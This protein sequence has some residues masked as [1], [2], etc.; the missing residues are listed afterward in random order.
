[1]V[2]H[3]P[4]GIGKSTLAAQIA[5]R[6]GR[7]APDGAVTMLS[8]EVSAAGLIAEPA[9]TDLVVLDDFGDNL[10]LD[11]G[12][13]MVRDPALAALLAGWT[14]KL[15][16]ICEIPFALPEPGP[17]RFVFRRVGP[18][19]RSGA[20]EF[21]LAQPALRTLEESQRDLAWRLTA[22]HP[23]AMEYLEALLAAGVP[24]QDVAVRVGAA[25]QETTGHAPART[26]P[27]ELA[28]AAAQCLAEAAGQQLLGELISRL[29][30]GA[31]DLLVRASA[32]RV[33]VG[34]GVLAARPANLAEGLAA[35]LLRTGRGRELAVPRWT[36]GGV[37]CR[38][39]QAGQAAELAQAHREAAAYWQARIGVP[40]IGARAQL[41]ASHHLRQ[42]AD[43]TA[44]P[45]FRMA[46]SPE[47][48]L[49]GRGRRRLR[50]R[51][52]RLVRRRAVPGASSGTPLRTVQLTAPAS[53]AQAM[54]AF[55][56]AQRPPYQALRAS[57]SGSAGGPADAD[58]P[59]RRPRPA[60]PARRR[61]LTGRVA[62]SFSRTGHPSR[63]GYSSSARPVGRRK[64]MRDGR[65]ARIIP[66]PGSLLVLTPLRLLTMGADDRNGKLAAI[67][68]IRIILLALI[69]NGSCT[70]SPRISSFHA[71]L[72]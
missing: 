70:I 67:I 1:M 37:H 15:L 45:V 25:V 34:P 63:R 14:G 57:L 62:A 69:D 32:F 61:A 4:G 36:A 23:R 58:R 3:G 68:N 29:T 35:G 33:P 30:A 66:Y 47:A 46:A 38:L 16:I 71:L 53:D 6:L 19:T 56:R 60:R 54:L 39:R 21:A 31:R 64:I 49:G 65:L 28:E 44:S 17:G 5:S 10:A 11:D 27:T 41:E 42:V 52:N 48:Q 12:R 9:G 24:F 59:V 13:A 43:L 8:G 50:R 2:L 40:S 72:P 7:L 26:E 55:V 18:L 22:G 51:S 20:A